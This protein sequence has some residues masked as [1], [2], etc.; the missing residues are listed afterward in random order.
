MA[1]VLVVEDDLPIATLMIDELSHPG[2]WWTSSRTAP[3]RS[4]LYRRIGPT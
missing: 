4:S 2:T 1:R 3:K